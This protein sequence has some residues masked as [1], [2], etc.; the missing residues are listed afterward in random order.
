MLEHGLA[1][2]IFL[3][4][5]GDVLS[6]LYITPNMVL[7]MNP[8]ARRFKWPLM[9][10]GFGL[11]A[12]PYFDTRLA[13]M[14]AVPSLLVTASNLSKGW[15]ARALGDKEM[16]RIVLLAA[17]LGSLP[18][19]LAMCW[20]AAAFILVTACTLTWLGGWENQTISSFA[21]GIGVYG[22][23]IAIHGTLF[24]VRVFKRARMEAN[25]AQQAAAGDAPQA[26]RP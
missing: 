16:E 10:A 3:G 15:M 25:A 22:A 24:Y 12:V 7:E 4:R 23:A 26:A 6:T 19:A 9:I 2:L 20:I 8:L 14:V 1:F 11:C 13:I 5:A 21:I 18:V 17:T